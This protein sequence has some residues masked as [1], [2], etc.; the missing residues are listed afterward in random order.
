MGLLAIAVKF[1]DAGSDNQPSEKL[2]PLP[3]QERYISC[4]VSAI[5]IG[6]SNW[7]AYEL[8]TNGCERIIWP[9]A[10]AGVAQ[11]LERHVANVN[12][13]GSNPITRSFFHF[14][15]LS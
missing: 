7:A 9:L 11:W 3:L 13:V 12:V 4:S 10:I 6:L 5:F 8:A 2:G 1:T 15:F 14:P